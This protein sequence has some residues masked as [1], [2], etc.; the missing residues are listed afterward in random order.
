[1]TTDN[2]ILLGL[3]DE[4]G[5]AFTLVENP[6]TEEPY[7]IGVPE[8]SDLR[9]EINA[10]LQTAYDDGT[11]ASIYEATVGAVASVTPEPPALDNEGC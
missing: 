1:M 2:V 11:W 8:G 9:C 3:A 10:I 4:A 7:G 5:D 6:F